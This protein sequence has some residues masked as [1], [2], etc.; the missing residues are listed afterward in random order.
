MKVAGRPAGCLCRKAG[1]IAEQLPYPG[2]MLFVMLERPQ[3]RPLPSII[4]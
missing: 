1:D 3:S 4:I 2:R